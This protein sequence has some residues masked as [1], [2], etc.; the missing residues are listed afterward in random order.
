MIDYDEFMDNISR[1]DITPAGQA[2]ADQETHVS[3]V[4]RILEASEAQTT[5]LLAGRPA[6]H[7]PPEAVAARTRRDR[8]EELK[9]DERARRFG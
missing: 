4:Q 3:L 8:I 9:V 5:A 2:R 1:R 7:L 6:R